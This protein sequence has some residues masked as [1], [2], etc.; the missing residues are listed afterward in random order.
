MKNNSCK[1]SIFGLGYVGSV[2]AACFAREGHSVLGVDKDA[3]KIAMVEA[4]QTPVI[5]VEIGE[6]VRGMREQ[7]RLRASAD[8][9]QAVR[10]TDVSFLCVGTPSLRSGKLDLGHVEH[11]CTEIG[12]GLARKSSY[13]LVVLRSTVLPGTTRS[14]ALPALERSSGK[15]AGV[16]FDLAYNPEFMREGSAVRDFFDPPYTILGSAGPRPLEMLKSLY[17]G[18]PKPVFETAWEDAEMIK[19]MSNAYHAIK[20][21]FANEMGTLA[22]LLGVN[23]KKV[24]EV[25]L[26]D[27]KLNV[28]ALYLEPGFAFGGSCLPKDV[29]ALQYKAKELDVKVPMLEAVLDSNIEHVRRAA[30]MVLRTGRRRI[31]MIGLSF[32]PGTDDLRESPQVQLVKHLIGEGC[33]IKIWDGQ[34]SLGR[35]VGSNRKYI[36][37]EIPHIGTLLT[38]KLEEVVQDAEIVILGTRAAELEQLQKLLR[39]DQMLLDL[40]NLDPRRRPAGAGKYEGICW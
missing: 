33:Q 31:G 23:T 3:G 10:E 22:K 4:G 34:V 1:I 37:Q 2:T 19:Y 15:K 11:V 12:E 16:D 7:G 32:K 18:I 21:G 40:I 6:L 30:E 29:R 36:E 13:H 39:P 38:A 27:T 35:L 25:F 26:S 28:S 14:L 8:A 24:T 17:G 5:E 9:I 20:V